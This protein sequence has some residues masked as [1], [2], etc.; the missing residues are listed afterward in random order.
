M[1]RELQQFQSRNRVYLNRIGL[2][3]ID[4]TIIIHD[5]SYNPPEITTHT[6][7][8][9]RYNGSRVMRQRMANSTVTIT[10]SVREYD[11]VRRQDIMHRITAWAMAGGTL[12]TDDRPDQRLHVVCTSAPSIQSSLKWA[13]SQEIEFSAFDQP[14]WEDTVPKTVTLNGT[15]ASGQLVGAGAASDPFVEVRV[16]AIG[17]ITNLTLNAGTTSISLSGISIQSGQAL[18]INYDDT[19]TLH[20][21]NENTNVSYLNKRTAASDDDLMIP[22]GKSST[23]SYTANANATVTFSVRGLYL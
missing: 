21:Y 14:F 1:I 17:A 2:T 20:I 10:F 15:S 16:K 19:H 22:V 13:E 8:R 18:I 9:A 7:D 6:V 4:P 5:V 12:T 3:D 11:Q 23:V